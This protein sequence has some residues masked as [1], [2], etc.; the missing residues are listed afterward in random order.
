M[1]KTPQAGFSLLEAIVAMVIMATGLLA[2]YAWLSTNT[3]ALTRVQAQAS[4]LRDKRAA[5]A[6]IE[7]VNPLLEPSGSRQLEDMQ[8]SWTATP[9]VQRQSGRTRAGM[10]GLFEVALFSLDVQV[11]RN[12]LAVEHFSV[13]RAGWEQVRQLGDED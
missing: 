13:R 3:F 6:L 1:T 7:T 5:L 10:P 2:L 9:I 12:R 8:I 4:A 11:R